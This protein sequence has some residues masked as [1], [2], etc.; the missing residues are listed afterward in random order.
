MF[1]GPVPGFA[2]ILAAVREFEQRFNQLVM[3]S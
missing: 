2:E 1:F 3:P